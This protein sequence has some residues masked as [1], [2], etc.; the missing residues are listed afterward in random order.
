MFVP[1]VEKTLQGRIASHIEENVD[2]SILDASR[3]WGMAD[4]CLDL[5]KSIMI[6]KLQHNQIRVRGLR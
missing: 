1:K 5:Q 6:G 2:F 3:E 4:P